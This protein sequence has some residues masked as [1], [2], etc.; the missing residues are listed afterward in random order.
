MFAYSGIIIIS[1]CFFSMT[2]LEA[3]MRVRLCRLSGFAKSVFND[4]Y[5]S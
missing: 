5:R 4:T 3:I 1:H 2:Y